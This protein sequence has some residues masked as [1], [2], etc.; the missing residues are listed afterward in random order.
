[1]DTQ[2]NNTQVIPETPVVVPPVVPST[3]PEPQPVVPPL[4]QEQ[5]L[6]V[7]DP[8]GNS[9]IMKV[10]ILILVVALLVALGYVVY[11]KF[12]VPSTA[13]TVPTPTVY[14]VPTPV[15]T[16]TVIP[17]ETP[18]SMPVSSPSASPGL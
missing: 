13:T 10:A 9:T 8:K 11:V 17:T 16:E 12:F 2:N 15:A 6:K 5:T 1:M 18:L 14:V 4:V 3:I 7:E